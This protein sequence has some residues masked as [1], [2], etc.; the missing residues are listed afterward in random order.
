META[1][2]VHVC[3]VKLPWYQEGLRFKCTGCGACCTGAPGYVWVTEEDIERIA[4]FL[5]ISAEECRTTYVRRV[6]GRLSLKERPKNYDCVFLEGK[7]CTIYPVRPKQ[8]RTFP[9]WKENLTTPAHWKR[10][11]SYCE[12]IDHED[13]PLISLEEI[14]SQQ[15]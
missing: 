7:R 2:G 12:G 5:N 8:C 6:H 15:D 10:A 4:Q 3:M 11:A 13:A 14:N 9:W 1:Q